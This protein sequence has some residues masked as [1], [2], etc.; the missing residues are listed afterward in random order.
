VQLSA[1]LGAESTLFALAGQLERA[2]PWH[3]RRPR[4]HAAV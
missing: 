4:I 1:D 3:Q 2:L